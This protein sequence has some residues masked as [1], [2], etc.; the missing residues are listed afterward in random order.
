MRKY[1]QS[2]I[3]LVFAFLFSN[4]AWAGELYSCIDRD[5][6]AIVTTSPQDGMTNCVLKDSSEDPSQQELK[7]GKYTKQPKASGKTSI[8]QPKA[9]DEEYACRN[10]CQL[11]NSSCES[12]CSRFYKNY[13]NQ[14]K[15]MANCSGSYNRCLYN[16]C[17]I[18]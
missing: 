7:R 2:I 3:C 16:K 1:L 11:D 18:K 17:N 13:K 8:E 9:K 12:D 10:K 15:C 4:Q 14:D 5:G 6:K